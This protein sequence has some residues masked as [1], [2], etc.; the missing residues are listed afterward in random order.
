MILSTAFPFENHQ[1]MGDVPTFLGTPLGADRDQTNHN[2]WLNH[3]IQC[4]LCY[5][6]RL[7]EKFWLIKQDNFPS[8][9]ATSQTWWFASFLI[10]VP[11]VLAMCSFV[12]MIGNVIVL[13][14]VVVIVFSVTTTVTCHHP[15]CYCVWYVLDPTWYWTNRW[16][17]D[18]PILQSPNPLIETYN[19]I[20]I[21][22]VSANTLEMYLKKRKWSNDVALSNNRLRLNRLI[23]MF[24]VFTY[25]HC[26]KL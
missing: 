15:H 9:L 20:E 16:T 24:H 11:P 14:N 5:W 26:H 17:L 23:I 13:V 7:S 6:V 10:Y 3:G 18:P 1:W 12:M 22:Q 25:H 4:A 19:R 2:I 8:R 21:G